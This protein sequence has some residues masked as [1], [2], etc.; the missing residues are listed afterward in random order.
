M[1]FSKMLEKAGYRYT[2]VE[3]GKDAVEAIKTDS[4]IDAV[5]VSRYVIIL[6]IF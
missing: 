1:I 2:A 6:T 5:L 3:N 4:S